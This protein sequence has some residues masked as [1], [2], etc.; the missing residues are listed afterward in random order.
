LVAADSV[1]IPMQCEFFA[2][3][4]LGQL[5]ETISVLMQNYN[6]NLEGVL[7]TMYDSRAN[8]VEQVVGEVKKFF[9]E[10]VCETKI[11][12]TIKLAEAPSFGKPVLLYDP[13]CKGAQAYLD[14]AKEFIVRQ[15]LR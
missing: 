5:S 13:S 3:E 6:L 10:K 1:L 11:P 4:G 12:R 9:K 7:F 15:I 2:L 8:L 14:F